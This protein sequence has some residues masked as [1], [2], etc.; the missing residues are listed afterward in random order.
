MT[1]PGNTG[2]A[3]IARWLTGPTPRLAA[4]LVG[5]VAILFA[6]SL[7]IGPVDLSIGGVF[8]GLFG[9]ADEST[10]IIVQEIRLPRSL[11]ALL[12][13]ITLGLAGA[14]LQGLLRSP[15]A[16]PSLLGAPSAAAFAAVLP[17]ALGLVGALSTGMPIAAILGALASVGLLLLVAGPRAS[18]L[19]LILAGLS[20]SALAAAGTALAMNLAPARFDDVEISFWLLGSLENRSMQHVGIVLPFMAVSWLLLSWDRTAFRALTLGEEAAEGLGIN[21]KAVRLR[22]VLGVAAGVGAAVA[23]AGAIGFVGLV[24]PQLM[25]PFVNHDP[26]RVLLPAAFAGGALLLVADIIVRLVPSATEIKVGIVT[27]L[28]GVPVFILLI[29]QHRRGLVGAP[30]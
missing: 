8:A 15:L 7:A 14:A 23:V 9:G 5:L 28:I 20:V 18:L 6:I 2:P 30:S 24:A 21:L 25:R 19:V 13:G 12:I 11:L 27:A 26:A 29:M 4:Q 3:G 22:V 10:R 17:V 16:A 1:D